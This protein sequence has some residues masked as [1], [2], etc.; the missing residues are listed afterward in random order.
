[1]NALIKKLMIVHVQQLV[2]TQ[3][4]VTSVSVNMETVEVCS[5]CPLY[6]MCHHM[7]L[8]KQVVVSIII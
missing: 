6:W 1:M 3:M 8:F 4:V 2:R 5:V 7:Y